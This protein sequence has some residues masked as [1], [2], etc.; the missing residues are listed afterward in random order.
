[1]LIPVILSGGAGTRLWPV[2]REGQPKPFMKLVD[3][4]S[5]IG[6]TYRRAAA[7]HD[8][9]GSKPATL[10]TVTHRDYYFM[11]RDEL[12]Q[13]G[14]S[15][16]FL[17]EPFA[18]NTAAAIALAA[19]YAADRHGS[20]AV[21]LILPADHLILDQTAFE[22]AVVQAGCLAQQGYLVTFGIKPKA[23]E[24][25]FGYIEQGQALTGGV[26]Y[27]VARFVEKPDP[28]TAQEYLDSGNY[29]WNSGM[30]AF[31]AASFLKELSLHAPD[32]DRVA[33][34]CW[35]QISSSG[36]SADFMEIP[37]ALFDGA[38]DISVDYAVFEKSERVAVVP[39]DFG[40][41]DI[42]SWSALRDLVPPDENNNRTRGDVVLVDSSNT[43]V[44]SDGRLVA[45]LGLDKIMVIDT[46]DALLVAHQDKVQDVKKI[47]AQLKKTN[48]EAY[49]LHRTVV[50][51]WGSYTILETGP[52][53]KIKH[54]EVKPGA[55][56][57]LQLHHHRSEHWVVVS[58]TAKI[59][60]DGRETLIQANEST[61]INAGQQHRLENPG[62][63]PCSMIEVQC[64]EY[65]GEDD[66]VRF[67]DK[68]GR[69]GLLCS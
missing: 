20:D 49:R 46:P 54:I 33:G 63:L 32:V 25:G 15:G 28:A 47:V 53:Y 39:G 42:G 21:L 27:R 31:Q 43:Y 19:Y 64:G 65:L 35:R 13:C 56:L 67:D 45:A 16:E 52:R 38:P 7:L 58:G 66:I 1:M 14:L 9:H 30:F 55:S 11:S 37:A 44:Q 57:S 69:A 26:G 61:Y 10:L 51:P 22:Q 50:R 41:S 3:G 34:Q 62:I 5:L 6:K 40:W 2:S 29:L 48:H 23:P 4:E 68:Y 59:S 18:R 24:T 17:L 8:E 36:K 12:T 60:C